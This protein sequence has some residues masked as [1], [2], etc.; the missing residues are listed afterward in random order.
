[1]D[2]NF[3]A[4]LQKLV[5][6]QGKEVLLNPIKCKAFL[7]DYTKGEY[8]KESRVLLQ[9]LEVGVQKAINTAEELEICKKQQVRLLKEEYF[10]AEEIASDVVDTIA[11]VLSGDKPKKL[12]QTQQLQI[13]SS[14]STTEILLFNN[15]HKK[16]N[17]I[18]T[19]VVWLSFLI[20]CFYI[21]INDTNTYADYNNEND[22]G[23][24]WDPNVRNGVI[25][26]KY[27]GS[28]KRNVC[29]P[30]NIQDYPVTGISVGAFY[31]TG[32]TNVTIPNGVKDIGRIAFSGCTK[33]KSVI[34]PNSVTTIGECAFSGC[35]SLTSIIIP[36]S[37]TTIGE[38]VFSGCTKLK[39][40][41]IPES[42]TTIGESAFSNC[43]RLKSINIPNSVT[44]IG[45]STF[46][47]CT[48][49]NSV[50]IPASVTTIG[51]SAFSNCTRLKS[52]N[53]PDSVTT[54]GSFTFS[55]CTSLNSVNI[56]DSITTIELGTFYSCASL[57]NVNIPDSVS[58]IGDSAFRHCTSLT[59]V[60]IPNSV[61]SIGTAAFSYCTSLS[62]VTIPN[63]ITTIGGWS[64]S[65]CTSLSSVT[66][67]GKISSQ[68]I[69]SYAFIELGD[70]RDKYLTGGIGTYKRL[71]G[72]KIWLKQ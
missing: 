72:N 4:L 60:N 67:L 8:K 33:L 37:V 44:T 21:V 11:L 55:G 3:I 1:M 5:N 25:I 19:I 34:I 71:S 26:T 36:D 66:F 57:T 20:F 31:N 2:N 64:F 63:S 24:D 23:I 35:T 65:N 18:I 61:I 45:S 59:S 13:Q 14:P 28:S 12:Q 29:I 16:R 50:N 47:G 39:S 69:D 52:I 53:I 49:L 38:S 54:I 15:T 62:S 51:E 42:V 17:M 56:P 32:I 70:L 43:T 22:F 58:S 7:S 30:P 48:S 68:S 46:S 40:V 9:A 41:N 10:L 6:E 27:T